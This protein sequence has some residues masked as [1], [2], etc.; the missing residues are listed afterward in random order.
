MDISTDQIVYFQWGLIELNA[1]IV[2][3]WGVIVLIAIASWLITRN[4]KINGKIS[5]TQ[6]FLEALISF[7]RREIHD[8]TQ[9]RADLYLPFIGSFYLYIA[10]ANFLSFVPGYEAPT[11]SL[12]TTGVLA[13]YVFFAVPVYG[14]YNAGL[15]GFLKHYVTPTPL[16]LPFNIIG[17]LSRTLALA[18]RLFGNVMSGT[19][20]VAILLSV[21]P[22][23][24]PVIMQA[25]GLLIGQIHAYIFAVLSLVYIGSASR[26]HKEKIEK[27]T[28]NS[29]KNDKEDSDERS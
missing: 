22:L 29:D 14:I 2:Y 3:S 18:V 6:A 9:S 21:A 10:V 4:I 24:F 19:L 25:L 12:T 17:E 7:M 8:V 15:K 5:R 13:A 1:T 23:F 20:I 26:A 28:E 16:M 11:G 27:K